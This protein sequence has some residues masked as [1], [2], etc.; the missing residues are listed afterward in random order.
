M[1]PLYDVH[2]HVGLDQAFWLRGW[3]PYASTAQDLL[4]RMDANGITHAVCFS[5][6]LPSA[7][8]PYAFASH[9]E[10]KLLPG[11]IPFDRENFLLVQ[12]LERIDHE[13][14]LLPLA[15]FD[16]SRLVN[17][18]LNNLD[19]L[20]G[21]I[22]GLKTQTTIIQ[23]P[24]R[25]LL[26]DGK[27]LMA[28]AE[29]YGLPVLMHTS[30]ASFDPWSQVRDC[31]EVAETFP[32][33][34]FCLAHSLRFHRESLQKA[35]HLSNVWVDCSSLLAHCHLAKANSPIIAPLTE[36]IEA[37]YKQPAKVL[38][39]IHEILGERFLWGSD[40]PFMSWCDEE[41]QIIF[42]YRQEAE[43]LHSLPESMKTSMGHLGP[44]QWLYGKK[45][46]EQ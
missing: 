41:I 14:R 25:S 36:R 44:C 12:E 21:K 15:M 33:V 10:I 13:H 3:W 5:F 30:V 34:R 26:N 2:T 8:D 31:L 22:T 7:F 17:E 38:M 28:F 35:A 42:S 46:G 23:S 1:T 43:V 18:Q 29:Q 45:A 40:N 19:K 27:E 37:D 20:V 11:R 4:R 9:Q 32:A 24:I 6:T 39:V 16:P